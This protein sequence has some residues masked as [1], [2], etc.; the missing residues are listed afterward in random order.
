MRSRGETAMTWGGSANSKSTGGKTQRIP[1]RGHELSSPRASTTALTPHPFPPA[2]PPPLHNPFP[3]VL[4]AL[5]LPPIGHQ[6]GR[7]VG[8]ALILQPRNV[9]GEGQETLHNVVPLFDAVG[10]GAEQGADLEEP[11]LREVAHLP[12][13]HVVVLRVG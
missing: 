9:R 8:T 5:P 1:S 3:R 13:H 11:L 7:P 6:V 10:P 4:Q 2:P 12:A